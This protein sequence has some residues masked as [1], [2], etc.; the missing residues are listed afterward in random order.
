VT[1]KP[2]RID[3]PSKVGVF[4]MSELWPIR[5]AQD[6]ARDIEALGFGSLFMPEAGGKDILVESAAFLAAT[7]RLV[8]GAGIANIHVRIPQKAETGSRILTHFIQDGSS[9]AWGSATPGS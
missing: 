1:N 2:A 5:D 4:W 8:V 3:F 6:V 9:S 7:E